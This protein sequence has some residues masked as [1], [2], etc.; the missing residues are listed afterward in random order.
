MRM[1]SDYY[2]G[3]LDIYIHTWNILQSSVSWRDISGND[4]SV[5]DEMIQTYFRD[6]ANCIRHVIIDDDSLIELPGITAGMIGTTKC[7]II[8]WKRYLYSSFQI[9]KYVYDL[10]P[11]S[12]SLNFRFDIICNAFCYFT[13]DQIMDFIDRYNDNRLMVQYIDNVRPMIG[14]DNIYMGKMK[15]MYILLKHLLFNLDE[16][17]PKYPKL[18]HQEFLFFD[19]NRIL[20]N[21]KRYS[22]TCD[23]NVKKY[24]MTNYSPYPIYEKGKK[25]EIKKEI[26]KDNSSKDMDN[27]KKRITNE[28]S[29]SFS[30]NKKS[31]VNMSTNAHYVKYTKD[32]MRWGNYSF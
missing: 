18:K 25:K 24:K 16:I 29:I 31:S 32:S 20:A 11:D 19:E 7:P 6:L 27:H 2:D 26:I 14:I 12:H 23:E 8:G 15:F 30:M 3:N 10:Y 9:V 21:S 5:T 4:S 1:L 22:P 17:V 28:L 13:P